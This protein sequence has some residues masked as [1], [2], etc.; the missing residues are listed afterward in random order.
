MKKRR[1]IFI[2]AIS[3]LTIWAGFARSY[4]IPIRRSGVV[5]SSTPGIDAEPM[6]GPR[7]VM[8]SDFFYEKRLAPELKK[9]AIAC[10][11]FAWLHLMPIAYVANDEAIIFIPRISGLEAEAI[12]D[13]ASLGI[14]DFEF[15]NGK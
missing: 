13:V 12:R 5:I 1:L 2:L 6:N 11:S 4:S 15:Q 14:A 3:A 8:K 7:E 9:H 10:S